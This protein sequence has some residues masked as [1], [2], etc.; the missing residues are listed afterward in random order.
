MDKFITGKKRKRPVRRVGK[1]KKRKLL[2][3]DNS[4]ILYKHV[5]LHP[6]LTAAEKEERA[7]ERET[8]DLYQEDDPTDGFVV[9]GDEE[10]KRDFLEGEEQLI[11]DPVEEEKYRKRAE[12]NLRSKKSRVRKPTKKQL[13]VDRFL[14]QKEGLWSV[15]DSMPKLMKLR[16]WGEPPADLPAN[17]HIP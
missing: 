17:K 8:N 14:Y 9:F 12:A 5:G 2:R 13:L 16:K 4:E 1:R 10:E 15:F 6:S 11:I 7:K 3:K